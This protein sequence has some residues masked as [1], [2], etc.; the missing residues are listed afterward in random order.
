MHDNIRTP[1]EWVLERR[2]G[3]GSVHGELPSRS[4]H[5]I[6]IMCDVPDNTSVQEARDV[7][8]TGPDFTRRIQGS[9]KPYKIA[10]LK[11]VVQVDQLLERF[12]RQIS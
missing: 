9:L 2:R 4:V 8:D 12:S 3:K 6:G 7:N 5:F 10:F 1:F 11:C